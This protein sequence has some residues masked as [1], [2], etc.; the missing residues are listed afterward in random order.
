MIRLRRAI[1]SEAKPLIGLY[2]P[3][4][5]GKTK[6]ALL[7]AKGFAG[8]MDHVAMIETESGRGEAYANDP[9]VGGYG[10][11][12]LREDFAPKR[13]G[14]ALAEAERAASEVAIVDSASHEW[15]GVGGVLAMAAKNQEDGR[16][17]P[18]VWQRPKIEHQREFIARILQTPIPLV[19]ACLR[20][21][22]PM[23]EATA[24]DVAHWEEAGKPGG[25]KAKPKI[26]EWYRSWKL[27]PKQSEDF[28]YE[29][30][31]HGWIDD[32]HCLHVTKYTLDE[33]M[34]RVFIDGEP[35]TI[36][37]GKRLAAWAKRNAKSEGQ[38][39]ALAPAPEDGS[40][41]EL[42]TGD[43][44]LNLETALRERGIVVE[45]LLA[46]AHIALLAEL[47]AADYDS[48]LAWIYRQNVRPIK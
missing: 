28:L 30:F 35:I 12:S 41:P 3:S 6:S 38:A 43:Q 4:G 39:L 8:G 37:T 40:A 27:E 22:Y 48:A 45:R 11:I 18:L 36:E 46:K 15:E 1:A 25:E 44:K 13:Y 26:G 17:G 33:D 7:L 34:R 23:V 10:V 16:K 24:R 5:H 42:I 21:K 20:A 9:E 47:P 32:R 29:C 31:V 2:A 14:E 19:I